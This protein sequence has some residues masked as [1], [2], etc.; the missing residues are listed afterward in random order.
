MLNAWENGHLSKYINAAQVIQ[1]YPCFKK[2]VTFYLFMCV[3]T[4]MPNMQKSEDTSRHRF[5]SPPRGPRDW[6]Q[7]V[8]LG[9][10]SLTQAIS[11]GFTHV[12]NEGLCTKSLI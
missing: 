4:G 9:S 8:G 1:I 6:T 12:F 2:I 11:S 7:L 10:K 3:G 5:S